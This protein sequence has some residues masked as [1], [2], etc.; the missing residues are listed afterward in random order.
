MYVFIHCIYKYIYIC[1]YKF[2]Y[3]CVYTCVCM[4]MFVKSS[5][6]RATERCTA[7]DNIYVTCRC[8]YTYT[9]VCVYS[10]GRV[11]TRERRTNVA[12]RLALLIIPASHVDVYSHTHIYSHIH[13]YV[14]VGRGERKQETGTPMV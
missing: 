4:C 5:G 3:I 1:T 8:I 14:Y 6:E 13:I 10:E 12:T 11:K 7:V 2:V 9:Y